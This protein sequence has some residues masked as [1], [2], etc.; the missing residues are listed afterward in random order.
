MAEEKV[1]PFTETDLE[2]LNQ[3]LDDLVEV[4]TLIEKS[5]RAGIPM[6]EQTK[7]ARELKEQLLRL[8]QS[9]FPGR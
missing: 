7:R 5:V 8:K 6:S 2:A 4:E 9:F 1:G 3:R